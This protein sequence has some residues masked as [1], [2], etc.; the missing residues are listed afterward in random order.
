MCRT[1]NLDYCSYQIK[2]IAGPDRKARDQ[3][4]TFIVKVTKR[5]RILA[6]RG[7]LK[8]DIDNDW[9]LWQLRKKLLNRRVRFNGWLFYDAGYADHAWLTDPV[10]KE[11]NN[12]IQTAW[13][14]HPV[15]GIELITDPSSRS[16]RSRGRRR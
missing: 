1:N 12:T 11:K 6:K 2:V 13:G 10:D 4:K 5:A 8:S 9:S 14:I 15:M 7:F 3:R 16:S